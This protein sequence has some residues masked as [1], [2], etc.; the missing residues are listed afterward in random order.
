MLLLV[1][2]SPKLL[3][4]VFVPPS[5]MVWAVLGLEKAIAPVL[6]KLSAPVPLDLDLAGCGCAE[7]EQTIGAA[8]GASIAQRAA[9]EDQV[10][11]HAA[12]LPIELFATV[13][14]AVDHEHA[15]N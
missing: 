10:A 9:A 14:Q 2:C 11:S 7:R 13:G 6:V 8:A 4:P 5:L 1:I 3:F 15:A 12:R